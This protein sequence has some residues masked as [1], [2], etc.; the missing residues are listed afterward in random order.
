MEP[1]ERAADVNP[2]ARARS[3]R[4]CRR[5][6]EDD[7]APPHCEESARESV[8]LDAVA[9]GFTQT[10]RQFLDATTGDWTGWFDTDFT[11][12]GVLTD[13]SMALTW[14]STSVDLVS[15]LLT[16]LYSESDGDAEDGEALPPVADEEQCPTRYETALTATLSGD[17]GGL[18]ETFSVVLRA[19]AAGY[20][21]FQTE[22]AL[23]E[24]VGTAT[25]NWS[26]AD[27][28][29]NELE[30]DV[31]LDETGTYMIG[32]GTWQGWTEDAASSSFTQD[33]EDYC[34]FALQRP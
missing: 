9:A 26:P 24:L 4:F 22:I 2:N 16:G 28:D 6:S 20:E 32:Q 19:T 29:T 33:S 14:D 17:D 8:D 15:E 31:Y 10:P 25:P 30:V 23:D 5:G 34:G 11:D 3:E 12:A 1:R 18:A 13:G 21:H 7:L 27:W